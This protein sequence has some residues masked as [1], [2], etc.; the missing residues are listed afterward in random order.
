MPGSAAV[1]LSLQA[2]A[3]TPVVLDSIDTRQSLGNGTFYLEDRTG[4]LDVDEIL[5]LPPERFRAVEG[6]HQRRQEQFD[7]VAARRSV[8]PL[9]EPL[10]GFIEINY[11]LLDHI[12]LF[13]DTPMAV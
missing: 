6:G 4:R 5:A 11:P 3:F 1:C 10:S 7:L 9:A 12:E 13:P 2:W 8:Q